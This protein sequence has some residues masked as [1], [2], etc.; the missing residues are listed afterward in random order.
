MGIKACI[1]VAVSLSILT[2]AVIYMPHVLRY[3]DDV[4]LHE[5][6]G[7]EVRE[8][9]GNTGKQGAGSQMEVC[10]DEPDKLE[11]TRIG[12]LTDPSG[13]Q[14]EDSARLSICTGRPVEDF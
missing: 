10:L 1:A 3:G 12:E 7:A 13:T 2:L 8:R 6:P 9:D 11:W 4:I 5:L 14:V